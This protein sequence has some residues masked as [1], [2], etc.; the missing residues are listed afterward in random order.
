MRARHLLPALSVCLTASVSTAIAQPK[1]DPKKGPTAPAKD[2]PKTGA[3]AKDAPKTGAGATGTPKTGAGAT[4]TPGTGAGA[5]GPGA[6]GPGAGKGAGGEEVQMS[7]DAPPKDIEGKE[8]NPDAPRL[9]DEPV[10]VVTKQVVSKPTGYPIEEAMRPIT[11]P[12]NM[13][14]VAIGPHAQVSPY[15]G[16][17]ALRARYGITDKAQLGLTYVLAGIY[18][19]PDTDSTKL[20]LHPGKAV[21]LDVTVQLKSWLGARLGVPVYIDPFAVGLSI[22]VPMKWQFADGKYALGALDD[23][24]NIRIKRFVPSFYQEYDNADAA[25]GT[26]PGGTGTIQSRGDMRFSAYGIMQYQPKTAFVARAG[27]IV[28][29]FSTTK[30]NAGPDDSGLQSFLRAGVQYTPRKYL[31]VGFSLGFD[32]LAHYGSFSPAG[33]LAFRI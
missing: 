29:D 4:G 33:L 26:R 2:A 3:G 19:S 18:D 9:I 24:L 14:E 15:R 21:G 8:E 27:V 28:R 31:D 23:F 20:G 6:T 25:R 10:P 16:S 17:D 1:P 13:S 5:T 22:G 12:K 30:T 7:E 32:D 11:L